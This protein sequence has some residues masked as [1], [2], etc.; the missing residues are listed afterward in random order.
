LVP[1]RFQNFTSWKNQQS[2]AIAETIG[3]VTWENFKV[4]DNLI[5]GLEVSLSTQTA[6]GT[7]QINGAIV[8]G[9]SANADAT[10]NSTF[11]YG[12]TT[13][14]YENFQV[15]NVNFYNFDVGYKA[16]LGSCS[17]CFNPCTTDSDARTTTFSNLYFD[18]SVLSR[19]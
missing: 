19:I 2:G 9:R 15:H 17:H 4:A 16:A 1:A 11:S 8:I 10:T 18:P 6:D 5:S 7:A 12:I 13:P 3:Y 14:R